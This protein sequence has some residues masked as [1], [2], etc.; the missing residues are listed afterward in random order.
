MFVDKSVNETV[1]GPTP[2][3]GIAKKSATGST[4][5]TVA[6]FTVMYSVRVRES[7]PSAFVAF[8]ETVKVPVLAKV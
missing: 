1:N 3:V 2:E 8:S 4:R 6:G 7:L 5:G